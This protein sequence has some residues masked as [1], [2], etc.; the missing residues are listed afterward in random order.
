GQLCK[1]FPGE[2]A[3]VTGAAEPERVPLLCPSRHGGFWLISRRDCFL[4]RGGKRQ[5]IGELPYE[6]PTMS[7]VAPNYEDSSGQLWVINRQGSR[8]VSVATNG[9]VVEHHFTSRPN[10]S[11]RVFFEDREGNRWWS[12]LN[13]GIRRFRPRRLELVSDGTNLFPNTVVAVAA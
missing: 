13:D 6:L 7:E 11:C 5:R 9:L 8:P 10:L 1:L 12:V 4:M 3:L 2:P